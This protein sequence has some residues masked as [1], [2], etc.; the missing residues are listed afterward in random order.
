MQIDNYVTKI[1]SNDKNRSYSILTY[2][3]FKKELTPEFITIYVNNIVDENQI[4]KQD[5]YKRFNKFYLKNNDNFNI[6]NHIIIKYVDYKRFDS[7]INTV[8]NMPLI[9]N[10]FL[11]VTCIDKSEKVSRIYFKI[12]HAYVDGYGLINILSKPLSKNVFIPE[13]KRKTTLLKTIYHYIIGTIVLLIIN[14]KIMF[15]LFFNDETNN[16]ITNDITNAKNPET[17]FIICKPFPLDKIKK[18]AQQ[19]NITINDFLYSLM[20][21]TDKLY[22]KKNRNIQTCSPINV[23]KLSTTNN[24]CPLLNCINNSFEDDNKLLQEVHKTFDNFKYS[25][26]IPFLSFIFNNFLHYINIEIQSF[27]YE[28]IIFNSN[29]IYSNIIGPPIKE[30]NENNDIELNDIHFL[31]TSKTDE[32]T[33]NIISCEDKVNI[34]C[35]FR[36]GRIEDKKRFEKCIYRAYNSLINVDNIGFA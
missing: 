6:D 21:K 30:I 20:I 16:D 32:V 3:D 26:F 7:F 8:L 35:S 29:Y 24:M 22:T 31:L 14:V 15:K 33:F 2:L 5:I 17:D 23:S 1:L 12:N 34:I 25:L 9:N 36:K 11:I 13:F 18:I 10:T 19:K 27:L 28:A 4:L